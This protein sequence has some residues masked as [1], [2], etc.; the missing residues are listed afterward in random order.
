MR[1]MLAIATVRA[2][3]RSST[4]SIYKVEIYGSKSPV[5]VWLGRRYVCP[6]FRASSGCVSGSNEPIPDPT[7]PSDSSIVH[8]GG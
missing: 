2:D 6:E 8:T 5:S 1:E 3:K 4:A 7:K